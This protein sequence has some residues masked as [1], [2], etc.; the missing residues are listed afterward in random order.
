MLHQDGLNI[1]RK[2]QKCSVQMSG[3]GEVLCRAQT[4]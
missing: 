3:S 2:V 4:G 1:L